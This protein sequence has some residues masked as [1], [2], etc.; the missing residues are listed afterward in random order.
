[1]CSFLLFH[2]RCS[3]TFS[4]TFLYA[5]VLLFIFS[6]Y[7]FTYP[8]HVL[9]VP[10]VESTRKSAHEVTKAVTPTH[11]P[12]LPPKDIRISHS[13]KRLSR[14]QDLSA[15]G[16]FMSIKN[17]NDT[18]ENRTRDLPACSAMPQPTAPPGASFPYILDQYRP[19]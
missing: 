3:E 2:S 13:C 17:C 12:P 14:P 5:Q 15:A 8:I 19:L 6:I 16:S 9:K 4:P 11:R 18:I 10:G 7:S 1:M